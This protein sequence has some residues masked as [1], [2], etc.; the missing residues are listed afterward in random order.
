VGVGIGSSTPAQIQGRIYRFDISTGIEADL[1]GTTQ[2]IDLTA[3]MLN[4]YGDQILTNLVF[5]N[6]IQ[7][8]AG[9]AYYV[10]VA[11]TDGVDNFVC[12]MSGDAEEGTALV[13]YFPNDWYYL[14]ML[15]MV[16]MNFAAFNTVSEVSSRVQELRAYPN[17]AS[18]EVLIELPTQLK[19]QMEAKWFDAT[20]QLVR[21]DSFN[22]SMQ[23]QYRPSVQELPSGLYRVLITGGDKKYQATVVRR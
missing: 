2:P 7:L 18:D 19:E 21:I 10:A 23:L 8:Y 12:A 9:E 17:P 15:P 14:D 22:S 1:L 5:D 3:S 16:R 20:G 11:S 4:G 6:P 13:R